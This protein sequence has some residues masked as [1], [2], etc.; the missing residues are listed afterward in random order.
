MLESI[1]ENLFFKEHPKFKP[2]VFFQDDYRNQVNNEDT[3]QY[4]CHS[5]QIINA[6]GGNESA[7]DIGFNA[8]RT[9]WPTI[10]ANY[11]FMGELNGYKF[12]I[13]KSKNFRYYSSQ[14]I[15]SKYV[16]IHPEKTKKNKLPVTIKQVPKVFIAEMLYM[17]S[18]KDLNDVYIPC[19]PKDHFA[20]YSS[21]LGHPLHYISL[22]LS[23]YLGIN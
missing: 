23:L 18:V 20:S 12:I 7:L 2:Y 13:M 6:R 4:L 5:A 10:D 21:K 22:L 1:R 14:K 8:L 17:I 11:P 16:M 19:I 15:N 9:L 3:V